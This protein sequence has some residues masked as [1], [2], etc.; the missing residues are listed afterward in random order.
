MLQR[1]ASFACLRSRQ[2]VHNSAL[3]CLGATSHEHIPAVMNRDA[4]RFKATLGDLHNAKLGAASMNKTVPLNPTVTAASSSVHAENAELDESQ[5]GKAPKSALAL[6]AS[7]YASLSKARLSSLVVLTTGAGYVIGPAAFDPSIAAAACFGTALCAASAGT[8]NQIFEI[9]R[10]ASMSRTKKRPL[11]SGEVGLGEATAFGMGTGALGTAML[12]TM[13]S[14]TVAAL[15]LGNIL[16]YA[17][18]YTYSKRVS[19]WNTWLGS[20][21]GAI[22]P[23][24]GWVA[25]EG[26]LVAPEPLALGGLL[27]LWQ[28]PH[29]FSLSWMHRE[30][31]A[32]GGFQMVATNDPT[33]ERSA[34]LIWKYS[35]YLTALPI[36]VAS[37]ELTSWMFAVEA[38]VANMY[39]L[40]LAAKFKQD[41]NKGNANARRIFMCSLWYLPLVLGALALHQN[42]TQKQRSAQVLTE[43]MDEAV[44]D[45]LVRKHVEIRERGKELCPHE[46]LSETVDNDTKINWIKAKI[47]SFAPPFCIK[48]FAQN[49]VSEASEAGKKAVAQRSTT[50]SAEEEANPAVA[51]TK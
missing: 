46:L 31:Y 28:F 25:A 7:H 50:A 1:F 49:I 24:M 32:K 5:T 20:I 37:Y 3:V 47:I 12:Y 29:F 27:F 33:G 19:E 48:L 34:A 30:D 35:L 39:L 16:L 15:G 17:G 23:L 38:S 36:V 51:N 8:F 2:P 21:V 4:R 11:P 44:G 9:D 18:A 26:A 14:P 45:V 22:P 41:P 40:H 13:T 43:E 42:T 6:K 10:D